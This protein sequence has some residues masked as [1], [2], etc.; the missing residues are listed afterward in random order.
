MHCTKRSSFLYNVEDLLIECSPERNQMEAIRET[1][2]YS[3]LMANAMECPKVT[4]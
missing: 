3:S 4:C 1:K 2:K